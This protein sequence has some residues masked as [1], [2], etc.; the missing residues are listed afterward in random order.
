[1]DAKEKINEVDEFGNSRI[2]NACKKGDL[3]LFI[4]LAK[5]RDV[6]LCIRN[7]SDQTVMDI[8]ET[9]LGKACEKYDYEMTDEE[10]RALNEEVLT[11]KQILKVLKMRVREELVEFAQ[12]RAEAAQKQNM[13]DFT[14]D[15]L[16]KIGVFPPTAQGSPSVYYNHDHN[17]FERV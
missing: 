11:R 13:Q 7:M 3:S 14:F 16:D 15:H 9:E 8:A 6:D 17:T 2:M 5:R 10:K 1:M 12:Q 4:A